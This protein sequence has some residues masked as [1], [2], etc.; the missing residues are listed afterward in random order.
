MII[1]LFFFF[2]QA[3]DGIRDVAV[4]GFRRVLFRSDNATAGLIN[5]N[6]N[7]QQRVRRAGSS[8]ELNNDYGAEYLWGIPKKGQSLKEVEDLLLEQIE[9]VKQGKFEDWIIPAI[10]TDF[11][12]TRKAQLES[13]GARV[14]L[15]RNAF[16]A[17][18]D[19]DHVVGEIDR[20]EKLSKQDV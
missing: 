10:I 12:K 13:D 20:I 1:L 17:Y 7:Q 6:L 2:F 9:L 11:K 3:E 15:M 8:P 5:L 14:G 19:W 16:L 18:Q 4:T